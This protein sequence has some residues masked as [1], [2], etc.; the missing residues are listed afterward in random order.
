V[1]DRCCEPHRYRHLKC[2]RQ[3]SIRRFSSY[4]IKARK[5]VLHDIMS[6][7]L[8][9]IEWSDTEPPDVR[10]VIKGIN[11]LLGLGLSE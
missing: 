7:L 1:T 5:E 9:D 8:Y 2:T 10:D 4:I 3:V 11:I 6:K